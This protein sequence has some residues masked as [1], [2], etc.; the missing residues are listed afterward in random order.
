M[1]RRILG[2]NQDTRSLTRRN[3]AADGRSAWYATRYNGASGTVRVGPM[4]LSLLPTMML[5]VMPQTNSGKKK[6]GTGPNVV[7]TRPFTP[8][9]FFSLPSAP[10]F[11]VSAAPSARLVRVI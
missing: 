3:F 2:H 6:T 10:S 7:Y 1:L 5:T 4:R 8:V 11:T 9:P